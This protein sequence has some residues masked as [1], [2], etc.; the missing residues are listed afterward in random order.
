MSEE[1]KNKLVMIKPKNNAE[2]LMEML[3]EFKA[4]DA[5]KVKEDGKIQAIHT[6]P[7]THMKVTKE[8][9]LLFLFP[10]RMD[11][12]VALEPDEFQIL[13]EK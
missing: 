8:G 3:K 12:A 2:Q 9:H 7:E 4:E 6:I 11:F 10:D 1:V 13:A 5:F